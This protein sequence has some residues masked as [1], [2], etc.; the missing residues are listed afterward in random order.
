MQ[1][2]SDVNPI[3]SEMEHFSNDPN[4]AIKS[5]RLLQSLDP[6]LKLSILWM[7]QPAHELIM[8]IV[9]LSAIVIS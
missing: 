4:L 1:N 5:H 8:T 2:I 3:F 9:A 7:I 6:V